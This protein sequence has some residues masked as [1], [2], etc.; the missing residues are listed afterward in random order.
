MILVDERVGSRHLGDHFGRECTV[1]RLESADVAFAAAAGL[2][3]GIEV[4]TV[5]DALSCMFTGRLADMQLPK[6]VEMYD[7]RYLIIQEMYRAEPGTGVLQR[8]KVFPS[9]KKVICGTWYDAHAGNAKVMYAQF[10]MWLHTLCE[11]TGTRLERTL[12]TPGTVSLILALYRWWQ[13]RDHKSMHVIQEPQGDAADLVRPSTLRRIAACLP[14]IGWER[15]KHVVKRFTS[16]RELA[17][18]DSDT[19]ESIPGIGK[20]IAQRVMKEINNT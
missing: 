4:K 6:M 5:T 19:W 15:S 14:C 18:A 1:C 16:L 10:E 13:R 8:W 9:E 20:V 2:G 12:D 7:V 3:V 11:T 17:L